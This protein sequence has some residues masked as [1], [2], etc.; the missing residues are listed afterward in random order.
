MTQRFRVKIANFFPTR[1]SRNSQ[2][3]LDSK[4]NQSKY[5]KINRKPWRHVRI[6]RILIYRTWA[7]CE[8]NV[9]SL[10]SVFTHVASI[11]TNLLGQKKV[12]KKRVQLSQ[13]WFGTPTSPPFHCFG[14]NETAGNSF[15]M[16]T[17]S[18][19]SKNLHKCS[20]LSE[21]AL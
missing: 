21:N 13:D 9:F 15:L 4:E 8:N 1:L 11:Y 6:F 14:N 3:R 2:K 20:H 5:R 19:F 17:L 12:R 7:S 18:F 10:Q 16:Q